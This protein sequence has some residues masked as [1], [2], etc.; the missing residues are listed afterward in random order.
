MPVEIAEKVLSFAALYVAAGVLFA[1]VFF[2]AGLRRIDETA[3]RGP[4]RFKLLILPG[5]VALWPVLLAKWLVARPA[6][7]RP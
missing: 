1:L 3:A 4:W 2:V 5:V 7:E 6:G